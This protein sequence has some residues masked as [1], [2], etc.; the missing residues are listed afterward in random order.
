MTR[1]FNQNPK[2]MALLLALALVAG[3]LGSCWLSF[4]EGEDATKLSQRP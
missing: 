4:M 1:M 2:L 3:Y